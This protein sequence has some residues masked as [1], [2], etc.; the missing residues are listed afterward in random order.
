MYLATFEGDCY[1]SRDLSMSRRPWATKAAT[2]L[3]NPRTPARL[4]CIY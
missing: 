3:G 1:Q 4:T 2:R